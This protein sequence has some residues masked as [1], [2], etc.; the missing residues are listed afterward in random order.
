[1]RGTL[2]RL[3]RPILWLS[4]VALF[5][6]AVAASAASSGGQGTEGPVVVGSKIDTE[7][8]LLGKMIV[9]VL[10]A[11]GF[12]VE[13]KT[14]LGGT[15]ILRQAITSGQ[16]DLYP[17]YTGNGAIFFKDEDPAVWKNA[18]RA[19]ETVRRLDRE[20]NGLVWLAPAPAN[21]T[22]AV[23]VRS[24]LAEK[25][26]LSS[27]EDFAAYVKKGG[28]VKLAGCEE[29]VSRP[30]ALPA[31][32]SAY[33]FTLKEDQLLIL[34]GCNTAQTEKAAAQG[35]SGVN[36]AMAYG[37]DG[38]L[39]AL[40]LT[41]LADPKSAQ[42]VYAPAPVI[43]AEANDKYPRIAQVLAPVFASLNDR[44]LRELNASIAVEGLDASTAARNYLRSKGFVK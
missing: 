35:T 37:T 31:F 24:D 14:E 13:D 41:T 1:M 4:C 8:G 10:E 22:W 34:S 33:G 28:R 23:A 11:N 3:V 38:A 21:N 2:R 18:A 27:L 39:A 29:F 30:D 15:P 43:R 17:E 12:K 40:G 19:Y 9:L 25:N 32:Q 36:A 26:G 44:T 7:G 16:I 20:R 42:P 6:G 5:S